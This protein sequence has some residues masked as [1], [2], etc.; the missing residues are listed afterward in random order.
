[1]PIKT[2]K[3]RENFRSYKD[4]FLTNGNVL[5]VSRA[6]YFPGDIPYN[7]A[8]VLE[9]REETMPLWY[10]DVDYDFMRTLDIKLLEGRGFDE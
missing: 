9:G 7:D 4:A 8:F 3:M 1:M 5:S 6:A 10:L 2:D